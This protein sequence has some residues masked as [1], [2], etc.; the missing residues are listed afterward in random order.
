MPGLVILFGIALVAILLVLTALI[1]W[2]A[3]RPPRH[4]AGYAVARG[5]P[6]EPGELGLAFEG[7]WLDAGAGVRLPVWE[8]ATN[9]S[10]ESALTAILIHG[11][12]HSRI[13]MLSRIGL[14]KKLVARIVLYDLRGHGEAEGGVSP[15]GAGEEADLLALI[16]RLGEGRFLL[17]GHSMGA[18]I[19]MHAAAR[20]SEAAGRIAGIVAYGPYAD[21]HASIKGRLRSGGFPTRPLTDLAMMWL[22]LRGIRHRELARDAATLRC[23]LLVVHGTEDEIAPFAHAEMIVDLAADAALHAVPG[24]GHLDAHAIDRAAHDEAVR[25]FVD[26]VAGRSA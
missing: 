12:G 25:G 14:W 4:T 16:E 10:N 1:V 6:S 9:A 19:A 18:V 23:P 17:V 15:L 21:F 13:D 3:R 11:W 22:R 24:G 26:R 7:W 5:L 2:E 20:E 8:I